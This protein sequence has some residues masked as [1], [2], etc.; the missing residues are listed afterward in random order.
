LVVHALHTLAHQFN[1]IKLH[2]VNQELKWLGAAIPNN[3][4]LVELNMVGTPSTGP[5]PCT[6]TFWFPIS[7][8]PKE[9]VSLLRFREPSVPIFNILS[10]AK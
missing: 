2:K 9:E 10:C 5:A 7:R 6:K 8:Q 1:L 3:S 4:A